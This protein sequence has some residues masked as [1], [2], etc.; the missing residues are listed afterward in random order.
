MKIY[1]K[2]MVCNRCK[3]TVKSEL[4]KTGINFK[5]IDLV[6]VETNEEVSHEKLRLLDKNLRQNGLELIKNNKEIL[7]EKI[8]TAIIE[9]VHYSEKELKL[10]LS[11]YLS[12]KLDYNYTYLANVFSEVNGISIEKFFITHKIERVKELIVNN[13]LNLKEIS[14]ITQ[15]SSIAHLSNQFKKSTGLAPSQY[16]QLLFKKR[17]P[18]EQIAC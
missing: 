10:T 17:M 13:E 16:R 12:K 15:Y 2:N 3:M 18:L 4:E 6:E 5:T 14:I 8:K 1:I 7:S 9:V 11:Y